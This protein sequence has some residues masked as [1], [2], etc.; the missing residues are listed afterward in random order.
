M[1]VLRDLRS[2]RRRE[3]LREL[4]VVIHSDEAARLVEVFEQP[5]LEVFREVHLARPGLR[6]VLFVAKLSAGG[7]HRRYDAAN[8]S[9]AATKA[10]LTDIGKI[11]DQAS[12]TG[13]EV[14]PEAIE[15]A[16]SLL[17]DPNWPNDAVIEGL[18]EKLLSTEDFAS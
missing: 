14:R 1:D 16:K 4:A 12:R 15:R 13:N 5:E 18:A 3:D 9:D 8:A 10:K 6:E 11:A 7:V 2:Q 17:A